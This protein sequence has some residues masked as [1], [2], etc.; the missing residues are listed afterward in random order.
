MLLA[1]LLMLSDPE[2]VFTPSADDILLPLSLPKALGEDL[3]TISPP[4]CSAAEVH[5]SAFDENGSFQFFVE[6]HSEAWPRLA[7]LS[8]KL[9]SDTKNRDC[10]DLLAVTAV[11]V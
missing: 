7:R 10:R 5:M 4:A 11:T 2:N 3:P 1:C 9:H 6:L 8:S